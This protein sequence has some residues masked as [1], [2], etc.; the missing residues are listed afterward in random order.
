MASKIKLPNGGMI[1]NESIATVDI[2]AKGVIC[3]DSQR[4]LITWFAISDPVKAKKVVNLLSDF[5]MAGQ[6]AV[7][8]CWDFLLET[9]P[10]NN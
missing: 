8:P 2:T 7:Q 6:N 4:R 9:P 1:S 5:A 3:Q 10:E